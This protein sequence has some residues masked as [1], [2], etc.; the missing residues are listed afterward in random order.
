MSIKELALIGLDLS[1]TGWTEDDGPKDE[2]AQRISEILV[3]KRPMLNE[4]FSLN[5]DAQGK[6]RTLPIL[7]GKTN[8]LFIFS[9]NSMLYITHYFA[10]IF[11]YEIKLLT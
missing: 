10:F 5:I 9:P 8:I 7:L 6:L 11:L 4:Y 3:E 1:E 2:L